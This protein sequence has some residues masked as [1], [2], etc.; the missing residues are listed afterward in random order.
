MNVNKPRASALNTCKPATFCASSRLYALTF[1][2][3][4]YTSIL[5]IYIPVFI[6]PETGT[7]CSSLPITSVYS[8]LLLLFSVLICLSNVYSYCSRLL[9]SVLIIYYYQI[10]LHDSCTSLC[11]IGL[12]FNHGY[13]IRRLRTLSAELSIFPLP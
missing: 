1:M 7:I 2:L 13:L 11:V 12:S 9:Y 8:H 3:L 6:L 5:Y 4:V 10:Y